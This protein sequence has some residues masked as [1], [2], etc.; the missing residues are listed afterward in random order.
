ML[1]WNKL[2]DE[3]ADPLVVFDPLSFLLHSKIIGV[4]SYRVL[5]DER[6]CILSVEVFNC[7]PSMRKAIFLI[8]SYLGI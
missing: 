1:L 5:K 4:E 6:V 3:L 7:E 8:V 2:H